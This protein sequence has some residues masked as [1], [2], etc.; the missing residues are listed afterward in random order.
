MNAF[1]SV[2]EAARLIGMTQE[3]LH[4]VGYFGEE[5]LQRAHDSVALGYLIYAM[6]SAWNAPR[7]EVEQLAGLCNDHLARMG[8]DAAGFWQASIGCAD[9]VDAIMEGEPECPEAE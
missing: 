5:E 9:P 3:M 6:G 8:L 1:K 7:D 2:T 4:L